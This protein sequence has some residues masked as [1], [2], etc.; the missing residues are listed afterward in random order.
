MGLLHAVIP[1]LPFHPKIDDGRDKPVNL[2]EMVGNIGQSGAN[3]ACSM[4][5]SRQWPALYYCE[6]FQHLPP[7]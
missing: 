2:L 3:R 7:H 1:T 5:S 6:E 4:P